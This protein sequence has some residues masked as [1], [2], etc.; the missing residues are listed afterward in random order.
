MFTI[1]KLSR[2][3]IYE[4]LIAQY[5]AEDDRSGELHLY[6]YRDAMASGYSICIPGAV[7]TPEDGDAVMYLELYKG[8]CGIP[9]ETTLV[10]DL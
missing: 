3:P 10:F 6:A 1:D 7:Y 4:Q 8:F 5:L 9:K 2:T